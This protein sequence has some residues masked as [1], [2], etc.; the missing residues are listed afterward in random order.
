[1][2]YKVFN[3]GVFCFSPTRQHGVIIKDSDAKLML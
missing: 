2:D 1:M 3:V